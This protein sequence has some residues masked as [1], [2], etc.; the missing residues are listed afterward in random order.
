MAISKTSQSKNRNRCT[1][2][3]NRCIDTRNAQCDYSTLS[4][5]QIITTY[6]CT[7]ARPKIR[8]P[9]ASLSV[10]QSQNTNQFGGRSPLHQNF[11]IQTVVASTMCT[12][13]Y[14]QDFRN[15]SSQIYVVHSQRET[16]F[17]RPIIQSPLSIH[18][19]TQ[20]LFVKRQVIPFAIP[21]TS[22]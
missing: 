7:N 22:K 20:T 2:L 13:A 3:R 12:C 11:E 18:T 16:V 17:V 6:N 21:T 14:K 19:L 9:Q 15:T 10:T 4:V 1:N 8:S 5:L